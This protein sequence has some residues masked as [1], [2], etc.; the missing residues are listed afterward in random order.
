MT[1]E[2]FARDSWQHGGTAAPLPPLN[3]LRARADRLRRKIVRRNWIEYV[4]GI[5]V[6]AVFGAGALIAPLPALRIGSAL[7]VGG[8]LVV[9]WQ[10]HRRGSP[11]TPMEHGGALSLLDFQRREL[12]R[13]RDALDSV[14]VWYLLPLIPGMATILAAPLLS[15]P[16]D[17][18]QWPPAEVLRAM[19][20]SVLIFAGV[21]FINKRAARQLQG[22]ID[23]IDALRTA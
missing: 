22:R 1:P 16:M 12:V 21:Y 19:G 2:E 9:L 20:F 23:Q 7:I 13:Q 18:W 15:V 8:T 11:L 6:I 10:L 5:F 17:Q 4:A 3:E 14:F